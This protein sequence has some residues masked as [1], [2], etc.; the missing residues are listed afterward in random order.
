MGQGQGPRERQKIN[1]FSQAAV[2]IYMHACA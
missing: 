1:T 2:Y